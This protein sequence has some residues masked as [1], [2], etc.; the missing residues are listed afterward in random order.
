MLKVAF[1]GDSITDW[2]NTSTGN[3]WP[4]LLL[5]RLAG[6]AE[7]QITIYDTSDPDPFP[8]D[9]RDKYLLHR[10]TSGEY[11]FW[12]SAIGTQHTSQ[13]AARFQDDIVS[14]KPDFCFIL[15]GINDSIDMLAGI[16][17]TTA[18]LE[19]MVQS[20]LSNH[21]TPVLCTLLPCTNSTD[22]TKARMVE[23]NEW[24]REFTVSGK[25]PLVDF[26]IAL[27]PNRT[28]LLQAGDDSGDGI[29]PSLAGLNKMAD[30]IDLT[31]FTAYGPSAKIWTRQS[32]SWKEVS[33][34]KR[35]TGSRFLPYKIRQRASDNSWK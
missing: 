8:Q 29:H 22:A 14:Y 20:C 6:P 26:A 15:G 2:Y 27:D 10:E 3:S 4:S 28:G 31:I 24:I 32:G 25:I 30:C 1:M 16:G 33:F 35:R 19:G 13:M 12:N 5:H 23:L 34:I 18:N 11:D 9:S 17:T 21:I 7:P